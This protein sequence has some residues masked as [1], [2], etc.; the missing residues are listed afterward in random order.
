MQPQWEL[1]EGMVSW[2]CLVPASYPHCSMELEEEIHSVRSVPSQRLPF[3]GIQTTSYPWETLKSEQYKRQC[4]YVK[5]R[6]L[7]ADWEAEKNQGQPVLR[8]C[9]GKGSCV[10]DLCTSAS[11]H[12]PNELQFL[13]VQKTWLE[14][15]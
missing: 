5:A 3:C 10:L 14:L 15:Y 7:T 13:L 6:F 12:I 8:A 11:L 1:G 4:V 2:T 9:R